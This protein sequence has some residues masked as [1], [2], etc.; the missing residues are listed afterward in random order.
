ML[1]QPHWSRTR[2]GATSSLACRGV[3]SEATNPMSL[4]EG[5]VA[6]PAEGTTQDSRHPCGGVFCR[7]ISTL[8]NYSSVGQN[9]TEHRPLQHPIL[10]RSLLVRITPPTASAVQRLGQK[11]AGMSTCA[12]HS[13]A[14][15]AISTGF[16][17]GPVPA[18]TRP[19]DGSRF[20]WRRRDMRRE[21]HASATMKQPGERICDSGVA[22]A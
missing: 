19:Q 9:R 11:P 12:T 22:V 5:K 4:T 7:P 16:S 13:V 1:G 14:Q 6:T 2:E 10:H 17:L 8:G 21:R 3:R 18:T 20:R 15:A